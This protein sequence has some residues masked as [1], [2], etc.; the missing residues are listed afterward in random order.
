MTREAPHM[1]Q[2]TILPAL[3]EHAAGIVAAIQSGFAPD[4]LGATI[5]G[6][7]GITNYVRHQT[8]LPA[9]LADTRYVVALDASAPA[10]ATSCS[11]L[12]AGC[13]ELR[14]FPNALC[15]NYISILPEC[16]A[17]GL[18]RK[19]LYAA[20]DAARC[21]AH[22]RLILDVF[23]HN[24]TA[25]RWYE[26][27]GFEDQY[28]SEWWEIELGCHA[29]LPGRV[30]GFAQACVCQREFGFSQFCVTTHDDSYSIGRIGERWFRVTQTDALHDLAL[31]ATLAILDPNRRILAILREG[32]LPDAAKPMAKPLV[33][34]ARK[35]IDLQ[36]LIANLGA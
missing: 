27:L 32:S 29:I 8:V 26:R 9:A 20:I 22:E 24:T 36:A 10:P 15:L 3:P 30:S 5:Y 4:I 12:V 19:L 1:R 6:C 28:F 31:L 25:N 14:L 18:G 33:R 34:L 23:T 7:S 21:D 35:T 16:R 17:S 11:Q 2:F 13:V